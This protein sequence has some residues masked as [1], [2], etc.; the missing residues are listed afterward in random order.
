MNPAV[1]AFLTELCFWIGSVA[2]AL[3]LIYIAYECICRG[4]FTFTLSPAEQD[5]A[6]R[7]RLQEQASLA[8]TRRPQLKR[9]GRLFN[10]KPWRKS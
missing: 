2:L 9:T 7:R 3:V 4:V 5:E 10:F 8:Y 6:E 1:A